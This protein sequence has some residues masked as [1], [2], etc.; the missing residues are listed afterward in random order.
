MPGCEY[1]SLQKDIRESDMEAA[2][3]WP[4]LR[5]FGDELGSFADTAALMDL[6]DVI[7]GVDTGATHLAGALGRPLWITLAYR[8]DWRWL[9]DREDCPWYPTARLFRQ[10]APRNWGP[11]LQRARSEL[12]KLVRG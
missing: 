4:E 12:E 11:V 5:H 3:S 7:I 2:R 1:V 10:D 8:S 6:M 9:M